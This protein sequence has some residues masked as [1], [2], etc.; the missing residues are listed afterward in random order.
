MTVSIWV[1]KRQDD[2]QA[3]C[4]NLP[5]CVGYGYTEDQARRRLQE[6]I[7]GYLASITNFVP[8]Q[9]SEVTEYRN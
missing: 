2:Y 3:V 4:A 1:R 9:I 8:N 7:R 5:G 6:A